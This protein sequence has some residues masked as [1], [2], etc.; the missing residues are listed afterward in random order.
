MQ[1]LLVKFTLFQNI[2]KKF[3][4][5]LKNKVRE[6]LKEMVAQK[7]IVPVIEPTDPIV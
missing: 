4:V 1:A 7:H 3:P 5:A 2:K 6:K